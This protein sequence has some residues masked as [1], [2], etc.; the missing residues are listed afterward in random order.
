MDVMN[1]YEMKEFKEGVRVSKKVVDTDKTVIHFHF[2]SPNSRVRLH[3][4]V[5][6]I[7]VY[8]VVEGEGRVTI[9]D[10]EKL[11]RKGDILV[12]PENTIHGVANPYKKP[13]IMLDILTPR[14][15]DW[16]SKTSK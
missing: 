1:V 14:P 7:D 11:V 3:R 16:A 5:D 12:I 4:H 8:Y 10:E 13:L 2:Y 15:K 9:G 6:A